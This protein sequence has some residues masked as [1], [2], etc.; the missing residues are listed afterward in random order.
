MEIV[1]AAYE[2][3]VAAGKA[4]VV[5]APQMAVFIDSLGPKLRE[6]L[7]WHLHRLSTAP[8]PGLRESPSVS[9]WK[10]T[11]ASIKSG[12]GAKSLSTS[13][14]S[15]A[16]AAK[17]CSYTPLLLWCRISTAASSSIKNCTLSPA[18]APQKLIEE[19][20]ELNGF[21]YTFADIVKTENRVAVFQNKPV[22]AFTRNH[23]V[24]VI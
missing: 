3:N 14:L 16:Q 2:D 19:S 23:D 22:D 20:L 13:S 18:A 1:K 7:I 6:K 21:L 15:S 17:S 10:S 11:A 12:S 8:R 24:D 4:C 9:P 5:R